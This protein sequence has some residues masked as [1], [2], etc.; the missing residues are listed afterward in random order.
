MARI[1]WLVAHRALVSIRDIVPRGNRRLAGA[2]S[3]CMTGCRI[4]ALDL[5]AGAAGQADSDAF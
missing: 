5:L 4:D 3:D 2:G 1:L